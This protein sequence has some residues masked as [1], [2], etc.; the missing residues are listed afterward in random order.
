MSGFLCIV[1]GE[2]PQEP[3]VSRLSGHLYEK[4]LIDKYLKE[5]GKCPATGKEMTTED[6]IEL[7]GYGIPV[8]TYSFKSYSVSAQLTRLL[9]QDRCQRRVFRVYW[10]R[11]KTNGM[12]QC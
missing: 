9:N 12:K 4:T 5:Y 3:V 6:I 1:S 8:V 7:Q 11:F 2:V 10:P